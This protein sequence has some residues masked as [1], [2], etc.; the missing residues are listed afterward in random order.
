MDIDHPILIRLERLERKYLRLK[1]IGFIGLILVIA[2][3]SIGAQRSTRQTVEANKFVLRG[4]DGSVAA[5]L[6][7]DQYDSDPRL[8]FYDHSRK[9]KSVLAVDRLVFSDLTGHSKIAIRPE[10]DGGSLVI[11][12][13][14]GAGIELSSDSSG[15]SLDIAGDERSVAVGLK[16]AAAAANLPTPAIMVLGKSGNLIWSTPE[17]K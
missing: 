11:T 6:I 7:S 4:A 10:A 2:L 12:G 9:V 16:T 5:E 14:N 3:A 17:Q 1:L 13:P 15:A 8:V